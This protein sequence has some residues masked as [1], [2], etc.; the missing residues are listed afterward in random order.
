M[1]Y[2]YACACACMTVCVCMCVCTHVC[3]YACMCVC[4]CVRVTVLLAHVPFHHWPTVYMYD[5]GADIEIYE[6]WGCV[7]FASEIFKTTPLLLRPR[8]LYIIY[9]ALVMQMREQATSH[10]SPQAISWRYSASMGQ[11]M[12]CCI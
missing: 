6:R 7:I 2:I 12:H 5:A 10:E 4:I 9:R 11:V 8:S 1:H 3:V